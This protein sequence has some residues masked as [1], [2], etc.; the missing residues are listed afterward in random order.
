M[1]GFAAED[2]LS[3]GSRFLLQLRAAHP[4][5]AISSLDTTVDRMRARKS[6]TEIALLRRA[7]EI[8]SRGHREAMKATAPGCG[9]NE[10]QAVLDGTFRRYGGDRPGYGS[11]V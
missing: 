11:I 10:I 9:E 5:L 8:S 2:S 3:R 6:P 7:A 4:T 1:S